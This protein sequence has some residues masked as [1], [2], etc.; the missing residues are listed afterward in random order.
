MVL[1]PATIAESCQRLE[2][3]LKKAQPKIGPHLFSENAS[4]FLTRHFPEKSRYIKSAMAKLAKETKNCQVCTNVVGATPQCL[5][6]NSFDWEDVS[7]SPS[8]IKCVCS[9][10]EGLMSW[11]KLMTAQLKQT[12]MESGSDELTTL[13]EHFLVVNGHRISE[14]SLFNSMLSLFA[15]LRAS[16]EQLDPQLKVPELQIEALIASL[17]SKK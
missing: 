3:S 9:S 5:V 2:G 8:A 12:M 17:V 7:Y 6:I 16:C 14:I 15:S 13:V 4:V 1:V 11:S 10:C